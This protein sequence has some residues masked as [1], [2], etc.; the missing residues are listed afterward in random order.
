MSEVGR[1]DFLIRGTKEESEGDVIPGHHLHQIPIQIGL[2]I[3]FL[4]LYRCIVGTLRVQFENN[5]DT[6]M[7][8]QYSD[9]GI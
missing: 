1:K 9:F 8:E 2:R 3:V 7:L 5:S 6:G 4:A